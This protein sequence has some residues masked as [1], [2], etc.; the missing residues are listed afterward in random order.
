[1][2]ELEVLLRHEGTRTRR[3]AAIHDKLFP[4]DCIH[5]HHFV[6]PGGNVRGS[7]E[8]VCEAALKTPCDELGCDE[9]ILI[10]RSCLNDETDHRIHFGSIATGDT[11][12]KSARHRHHHAEKE[13]VIAFEMEGA[14]VWS[15]FNRLIIKGVCDD[16]DSHKNKKWQE[17]AAAVAASV[18]KRTRDLPHNGLSCSEKRD[19]EN[20][21]GPRTSETTAKPTAHRTVCDKSQPVWPGSRNHTRDGWNYKSQ[22]GPNK[23]FATAKN[24]TD[25]FDTLLS[26]YEEIGVEL[27]SLGIELRFSSTTKGCNGPQES[28]QATLER[29]WPDLPEHSTSAVRIPGAVRQ[30]HAT[31][32][33]PSGKDS[34]LTLREKRK[35]GR[36]TSLGSSETGLQAQKARPNRTKYVVTDTFFQIVEIESWSKA[37]LK[38][39]YHRIWISPI[40]LYYGS[41]GA[42]E[43]THSAREYR[44]S[45]WSSTASMNAKRKRGSAGDFEEPD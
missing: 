44:A 41:M 4:P 45:T 26:A 9:S 34:C 29:L 33:R 1:M 5:R 21:G 36:E 43:L 40:V 17:Y 39:G 14:G 8:S 16:A 25:I 13:R 12:L 27:P 10:P 7:P 37:G 19:D 23:A 32:S 2:R 22:L 18:A 28:A 20:S 11:V 3:P 31:N 15:K 42:Q 38:S 6:R 30:R 35:K 24:Q